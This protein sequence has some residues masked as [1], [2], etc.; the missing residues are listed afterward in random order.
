MSKN[1]KHN[2]TDWLF[3]G[4]MFLLCVG[5]TVLQYRWTGE[6]ANAELRRL[7]ADLE[8]QSR[9]LTRA[10]DTELS[11]NCD[12]LLPYRN[13]SDKAFSEDWFLTRFKAWKAVGSRPMFS[14][15]ALASPVRGEGLQL[16]TRDQRPQGPGPHQDFVALR[17]LQLSML[18]QN[19][20][21]FVR[22]NWPGEWA[23]L[24]E[25]LTGKF[26]GASPPFSDPHGALMEFPIFDGRP[27]R[28]GPFDPGRVHWLILE[29]DINYV[30]DVWMP[31][32]ATRYLDPDR[33]GLNVARVE[34]IEPTSEVLYSS[35]TN[36]SGLGAFAVTVRFNQEGR[37]GEKFRG[38][39]QPGHWQLETWFRP[40]ALEA[41]VSASRTRNLAVAMLLNALM[42][43]TGIVL[44][45]NTRRS[46]QLAEAQMDFV[47]NVSHELRT[48][49]TVI[50][51]AAHN[52]KRGVVQERSQ[53][54]QYSG[55]IL[56]HTEQLGQ[57]VEQLLEL[58]GAR[59]NRAGLASE[60]VALTNVLKDAIVAAEHDT[61]A[62]G[63]TV[64]FDAPETVPIIAGDA[65]ALRR[66]FQ[67]L[68]TNAAKHGGDGKWIG[69]SVASVN[70]K[71]PPTIEVLVADRGSGIPESEQAE[72]FKPFVRGAAAKAN[73]VR[74][75]GLGLTMVREI[76]E[77]HHGEVSVT[78]KP[79]HG[80]TFIVRLPGQTHLK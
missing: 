22:T 2:Y 5:L 26:S 68:I 75:S 73:Q 67:N 6:I 14:R 7:R 62:A 30:R 31:E 12:D 29:L 43:T 4:V 28:G 47:A 9:A 11:E 40:G 25:N 52:L 35:Q 57:M 59:K 80:A 16:P 42:L 61:K 27:P 49:L 55:L 23:D 13:D 69:V 76:V 38:P 36:N 48:P 18:D 21:Q 39:P 72:I 20:Q 63:C 79:G 32:L 58:A 78:S 19:S 33:R 71:N 15:I 34:T 53:V 17:E 70:G 24:D 44:V 77:L 51:G 54:E 56:Q 45:R 8:V 66:V 65:P 46:R 64:Q 60:P 10:F 3:A 37:S 74:G 41:T 1:V 50:R